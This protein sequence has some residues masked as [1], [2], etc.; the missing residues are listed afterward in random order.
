M[1]GRAHSHSTWGHDGPADSNPKV[2][3]GTD[4]MTDPTKP[5]RM[6]SWT[7]DA[8]R[9]ADSQKRLA[10]KRGKD[11]SFLSRQMNVGPDQKP[12][13]VGGTTDLLRKLAQDARAEGT[14][15]LQ[16]LRREF[17]RAMA[18]SVTEAA[19]IASA[20][21]L[22]ARKGPTIVSV[23][24]LLDGVTPDELKRA[25]VD[26][27]ALGAYVERATMQVEVLMDLEEAS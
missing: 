2:M 18:P 9:R 20:R 22:L 21:E 11:A 13:D 7:A 8:L 1:V 26:L 6:T 10:R 5:R 16:A 27:T 12:S 17:A 19:L 25:H 3:R 23:A 4:P 24:E 15:L 14:R